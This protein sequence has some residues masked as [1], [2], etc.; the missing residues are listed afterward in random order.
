MIVKIWPIKAKHGGIQKNLKAS[1]DYVKDPQKMAKTSKGE[2]LQL[3][4]ESLSEEERAVSAYPVILQEIL[5][6]KE[7]VNCKI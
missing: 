5:G 3:E 7:I 1:V 6:C 4:Y 2:D